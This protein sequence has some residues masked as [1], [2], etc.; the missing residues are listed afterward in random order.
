MVR[1][2]RIVMPPR[3]AFD[4]APK[5][6]FVPIMI[7]E[8]GSYPA[9]ANRYLDERC[10]GE[11]QLPG[12]VKSPKIPT[13]KSRIDIASRLAIFLGWASL[14]KKADWRKYV[15]QDDILELYQPDLISGTGSPSGRSLSPNTVNLYVGE[16]CLFLAWAAE[17][18]YRSVFKVPTRRTTYVASSSTSSAQSVQEVDQR[19]G[20]FSPA[21][22]PI[23]VPSN[24][25]V[26]R[27]LSA[28]QIRSPIKAMVFELILRTGLRISEANLM[29]ATCFPDKIYN[30]EAAWHPNWIAAGKVPVTI[31]YGTKG[32]K[33]TPAS[34]LG[35][36]WRTIEVPIDL[37]ER[38]WHYKAIVRPNL[39]ARFRKSNGAQLSRTDRLWLG[40]GKCQ[41]VSNE[42]LRRI[43]KST[44]HCPPDWHPHIGRHFYAIQAVC[45]LTRAHLTLK[46]LSAAGDADFGWL[47]GLLSGQIQLIL[48]PLMG[49]VSAAT[50]MH[51]LRASVAKMARDKGHPSVR[52]NEMVDAA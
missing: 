5:L 39:L 29:R 11:W 4:H 21:E 7:G 12:E 10:N 24:E 46:Q 37:A 35:T 48:S 6:Q 1:Q 51:Y 13:L 16:A 25:E 23:S 31:K 14:Q 33:V 50:T 15:Y 26:E 8:D 42:M 30:G 44:P 32:G 38:I 19:I 45:E 52:W 34:E 43:W 40:E 9:E 41:P 2:M 36:R 17:R 3:G 22:T 28:V 47:H 20:A 18:G 27:W 49:H